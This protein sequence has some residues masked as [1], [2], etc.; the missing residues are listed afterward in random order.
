[1]KFKEGDWI[2][3]PNVNERYFV[4]R[5]GNKEYYLHSSIGSSFLQFINDKEFRLIDEMLVDRVLKKYQDDDAS[6]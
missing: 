2:Y 1:M 3:H 6:V 4:K 5:V